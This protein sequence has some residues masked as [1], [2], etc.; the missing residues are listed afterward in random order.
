MAGGHTEDELLIW[1]RQFLNE[2]RQIRR[3]RTSSRGFNSNP[4][5]QVGGGTT[6]TSIT[7]PQLRPPSQRMSSSVETHLTLTSSASNVNSNNTLGGKGSGPL[8]GHSPLQPDASNFQSP[9]GSKLVTTAASAQM[10]QNPHLPHNGPSGSAAASPF[11]SPSQAHLSVSLRTAIQQQE[12]LLDATGG[13]HPGAIGEAI[14][15][16]RIDSSATLVDTYDSVSSKKLDLLIFPQTDIDG[17]AADSKSSAPSI[18][19]GGSHAQQALVSSPLRPEPQTPVSN[20][21]AAVASETRTSLIPV[22]GSGVVSGSSDKHKRARPNYFGSAKDIAQRAATSQSPSNTPPLSPPAAN[23]EHNPQDR[24][25][26]TVSTNNNMYRT[27]SLGTSLLDPIRSTFTSAVNLKGDGSQSKLSKAIKELTREQVD[28]HLDKAVRL[29]F[30]LIKETARGGNKSLAASRQNSFSSK[31]ARSG[32]A[33]PTSAQI[34]QSGKDFVF[35]PRRSSDAESRSETPTTFR[36]D[37]A[38]RTSVVSVSSEG[39]TGISAHSTGRTTSIHQAKRMNSGTSTGNHSPQTPALLRRPLAKRTS[40]A[41]SDT[42]NSDTETTNNSPEHEMRAPP[43][44]LP[45]FTLTDDVNS[46]G[47]VITDSLDIDDLMGSQSLNIDYNFTESTNL[48]KETDNDGNRIINDHVVVR[49][50]GKGQYGTVKLA[51][52]VG[53]PTNL[54]AIKIINRSL[55]RGKSQSHEEALKKEIAVM[56]KLRHQNIVTLRQVVNDPEADKLYLIMDFVG[57]DHLLKKETDPARR[58]E[59]FLYEPIN[60]ALAVLYTRQLVDGLRYLHKHNIVHRDIKPENIMRKGNHVYITDFGVS[61]IVDL[62]PETENVEGLEENSPL[63][64]SNSSRRPSQMASPLGLSTSGV[65]G[66]RRS[67]TFA[68]SSFAPFA[69]SAPF[70]ASTSVAIGVSDRP[71][72]VNGQKGTPTFWPPEMFE[73]VEANDFDGEV[74]DLWSLGVTIYMMLTGKAPFPAR[75]LYCLRAKMTA[76]NLEV[77]IPEHLSLNARFLLSAMLSKDQMQR[78]TLLDIRHH[79]FMGGV[80]RRSARARG[81]VM[82]ITDEHDEET[83]FATA[84]SAIPP[85]WFFIGRVKPVLLAMLRRAQT[86]IAT[87]T[88][89]EKKTP[90]RRK[91]IEAMPH[92]LSPCPKDSRFLRVD[93]VHGATPQPNGPFLSVSGGSRSGSPNFTSSAPPEA[94]ST[95]R[96]SA[97]DANHQSPKGE[98]FGS[99]YFSRANSKPT[100]IASGGNLPTS[101]SSASI[102]IPRTNSDMVP[103][104]QVHSGSKHNIPSID[105]ACAIAAQQQ[106]QPPAP[107][108]PRIRSEVS[109]SSSKVTGTPPL[110]ANTAVSMSTGTDEDFGQPMATQLTVDGES[111]NEDED[112]NNNK[113][114]EEESTPHPVFKTIKDPSSYPQPPRSEDSSA[115]R[116]NSSAP[117]RNAS[118]PL[119]SSVINRHSSYTLNSGRREGT[120]SVGAINPPNQKRGGGVYAIT[121]LTFGRENTTSLD[122]IETGKEMAFGPRNE[123]SPLMNKPTLLS[124]IPSARGSFGFG[125]RGSSG[126]LGLGIL[127]GPGSPYAATNAYSGGSP[128]GTSSNSGL[129][130]A[131]SSGSTNLL[132]SGSIPAPKDAVTQP[133]AQHPS[134]PANPSSSPHRSFNTSSSTPLVPSPLS[135]QHIG[136]PMNAMTAFSAPRPI[137]APTGGEPPHG[138]NFVSVLSP[139]AATIPYGSPTA[140]KSET[141]AGI[142]L[143]QAAG[144][145][146]NLPPVNGIR[147]PRSQSKELS[148]ANSYEMPPSPNNSVNSRVRS[149]LVQAIASSPT[150]ED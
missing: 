99:G 119:S 104:L 29:I 127:S 53:D 94:P 139:M 55:G 2:V 113:P 59:G 129:L 38:P 11:S 93:C 46:P 105:E 8:G 6:Q 120:M 64:G 67:S 50:L 43:A 42:S 142:T 82:V 22:G 109:T 69:G 87:G 39:R 52:P 4:S 131:D 65:A 28:F 31:P 111:S 80:D 12:D 16:L 89:L 37:R 75:N 100:T 18:S 57:E 149:K 128:S 9:D 79:P 92:S 76:E 123:G 148:T 71:L 137:R 88:R 47:V 48:R 98:G 150:G 116:A 17:G 73:S 78:L 66:R 91:T 24:P 102:P 118:T 49:H 90:R 33:T 15:A 26:I 97:H 130:A 115:V 81:S 41:T 140:F 19:A 32:E 68:S 36:V 27:V 124:K 62:P 72:I 144:F 85:V 58:A 86:R 125:F 95:R 45:I 84:A 13:F 77:E 96:P 61:E 74:H 145:S 108:L 147:T 126:R 21:N 117:Q 54:V 60:E 44:D 40:I 51:H 143:S 136:T 70:A 103:F 1:F 5:S 141:E 30:Q 107:D 110:G 132:N 56:K 34:L 101:I 146:Q 3:K 63:T 114:P 10:S 134:P 35:P 25:A 14:K 7:S 133:L 83:A 106:P 121:G 23:T 135:P 20:T 112:C 138:K 122:S